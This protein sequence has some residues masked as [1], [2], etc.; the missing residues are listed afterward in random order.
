ML[1]ALDPVLL[2][3]IQFAFVIAFHII[4]PALSIGLA[5]FLAVTEFQYL[6]TGKKIYASIYKFWVKIFA[7]SFGLGV[8]SGVVMAYQFG[9]NWAVFADKTGSI[10]GPLLAF[11]T[12]TAFFLEASFLG[13]MLFGWGRVSKKMHFASTAI[14]AIGTLISATWIL[15]SNSFMQTP[16]GFGIDANGLLYPVD[17]LQIVFNP[18]FPFR[19]AHMVTAAFLT[20]AFVVGGVGAYYLLSKKH[21]HVRKHAQIMLSMAMLMAVF[22]AP[23]QVFLGD[24]HGINTL[25]HQPLKVSAMEGVWEDERGAP[26]LLFAIPDQENQMNHFEIGIPKLSSVILTH[27]P[28]GLVPG[29]KR[30][31]P[32]DQPPVLPVFFSFRIM[33]GIGML[34]LL[35]GLI[36]AY[37]FLRKKQFTT[38][39]FLK[40]WVG[41]APM[42]FV[43][44]IAG[45]F[46]TEIGRQPWTVYNVLRTED[47]I[48]PVMAEQVLFTLIGFIVIYTAVFGAGVYF[49]LKTIRSGPQRYDSGRDEAIYHH[50]FSEE[51]AV[52]LAEQIDPSSEAET[53]DDGDEGFTEDSSESNS[54]D[55]STPKTESSHKADLDE[56]S[57]QDPGNK[58]TPPKS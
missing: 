7:V 30:A 47:S 29:L 18:S 41:M 1:D 54:T 53:A 21:Q 40:L 31:A 45:W 46:T 27:D 2:A 42:G 39:W 37:M 43:A 25:E 22:V 57:S 23:L 51:Y 34:M 32:E 10:I 44:I 49:I 33:V 15:A 36:S 56:S 8:V 17:W 28:N 58:P 38:P 52:K 20:T 13:I 9:T 12:L 26:L 3:R 48:S 11:E 24:M 55:L 4:F 5:S 35:T 50:T 14:V 6:R 19:L 16:Q